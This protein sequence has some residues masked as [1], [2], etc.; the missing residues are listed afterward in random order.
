MGQLRNVRRTFQVGIAVYRGTYF[1][2]ARPRAVHFL[3]PKAGRIFF[4]LANTLQGL[5]QSEHHPVLEPRPSNQQTQQNTPQK[6][7]ARA[8]FDG[9][10]PDGRRCVGLRR[11]ALPSD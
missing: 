1:V 5:Q 11:R 8:H 9:P 10:G 6:V 7:R 4:Y 3:T 2:P